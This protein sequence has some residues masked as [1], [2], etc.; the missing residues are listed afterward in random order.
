[1]SRDPE[2]FWSG[3][4]LNQLLMLAH[5]PYRVWVVSWAALFSLYSCRA[6][7]LQSIKV[8]TYETRTTKAG[9]MSNIVTHTA[10][11]IRPYFL[12]C[13]ESFCDFSGFVA[14]LAYR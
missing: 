1:M 10:M 2:W 13:L 3:L 7:L 4:P 12:A 14:S 9:K 6:L 5:F 11:E 8:N